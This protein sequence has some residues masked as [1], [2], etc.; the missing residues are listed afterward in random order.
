MSGV[1][2][3]QGSFNSGEISRRLRARIN[4]GIYAA[5]VSE[6]VGFAPLVEGAAEAMPGTIH[7][8][9]APGP[10]RL[11][12][13]EYNVTQGHVLEF[14]EAKVRVYTNDALIED[15][16]APVE[17]ASPYSF[18]Q[19][20]ALY[21]HQSYDV[22]YCCHREVPTRE[23]Y[24]DGATSFGFD[25][26]AL[27]NGPF[28]PRNKDEA[29]TVGTTGLTGDVTLTASAAIFEAGDV[30]GLFRLEAGDFGDI[31]AWEPGITVNVGQLVTANERVYRVVAKGAGGKTGSWIPTH[32]EGVEWDG[33]GR[34]KDVNDENAAGVQLEYVHDR[35]G[36]LRLTGYV[37]PTEMTATVLRRL[38]FSTV[39]AAPSRYGFLGRYLDL[40]D[41]DYQEYTPDG[42]GYA[43]GTWRW[44]FGAFSDR[45]GWPETACIWNERLILTKDQTGYAGCAGDLRNFATTNELGDI[46]NDMA[47]TF[48]IA[49]PNPIR[50]T[51]AD[52]KLLLLTAGGIFA[53]GP[54]NAAEGIGPKNFRVDRQSHTGCIADVPPAV[55]DSRAL[56]VGRSG[57]RIYEA[58]FDPAR[59]VEKATDLTRYARHIAADGLVSIAAQQEPFNFV[60]AAKATGGLIC[61]AYLPDE[62]VLGWCRRD[63]ADGVASRSICRITDP[64]G[65]FDQLWIAA[66]FAGGWHVLRMAPWR[67]DGESDPSACMVDMAFVHDG[68]AQAA[69]TA[70]H[71]AGQTVDV[72][73]DGRVH[74]AVAVDGDG[75]FAIPHAAARVVAGL[76]F[77]A[78]IESLPI[79]AGGDNGPALGKKAKVSRAWVQ[80][81]ASRG[82]R[83]GTP[84][85]DDSDGV[86][87]DLEQQTGSSIVDG[88]FAPEDGIRFVEAVGGHTRT[89]RLRIERAAPV[90]ATVLAWGAEIAVQ[91]R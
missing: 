37:S 23:F 39:Q 72:V 84:A 21:T 5:A 77:A 20:G 50:A 62:E 45:R 40:D 24:R 46:S 90:Q 57:T 26:L 91:Q 8:A 64:A 18:A 87:A 51:V 16:G 12:R 82:L 17:V 13:F 75:D 68:A 36:I 29:V 63:M 88:A 38:P 28:E 80:V 15:G 85:S 48:T 49:D 56:F 10:C 11:L 4:L 55:L 14:S 76:P 3:A 19:V 32:T 61:G 34:G 69:F 9:E 86:M 31:T 74:L 79:E 60:W 89:P 41:V 73:A 66:E 83:F 67:E 53:V 25:L 47:F 78:A 52:E 43:Y 54:S 7:V 81:A 42:V 1:T 58:D 44:S 27:E 22:L 33:I 30:G 35:I 71:L 2:T 6:M 70:P 65:A 59:G